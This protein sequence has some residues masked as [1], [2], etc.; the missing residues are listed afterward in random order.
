MKIGPAT[1]NQIR[2]MV[3]LHIY[4]YMDE[5]NNA[6]EKQDNELTIALSVKLAPGKKGGTNIDVIMNF[7]KDRV[8]VKAST[9][10]DENQKP[11]PFKGE[12]EVSLTYKNNTVNLHAKD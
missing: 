2:K 10:V 11:L 12:D 8:K 5:I 1:I 7:V 3:N 4:D 9:N 6:Y